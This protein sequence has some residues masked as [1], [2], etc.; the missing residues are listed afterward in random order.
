MSIPNFTAVPAALRNEAS[1]WEDQSGAMTAVHSAAV[2]LE[3]NGWQ[4]GIWFLMV[5][6]YMDVVNQI[7]ALTS[8][9]AAELQNIATG[10]RANA[11]AYEASDIAAGG[12]F[13]HVDDGF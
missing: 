3:L 13:P 7:E 6:D 2:P 4:A 11:T 1:V 12:E 10:L 8:A 9:G 5:D